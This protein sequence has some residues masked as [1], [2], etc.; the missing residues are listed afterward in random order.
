MDVL[1]VGGWR[2]TVVGVVESWIVGECLLLH[3][4]TH[5][6]TANDHIIGTAY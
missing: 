3:A 6:A 2:L 5:L 1:E 4:T